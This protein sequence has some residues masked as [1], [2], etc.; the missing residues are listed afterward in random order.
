[1]AARTR[2]QRRIDTLE[3]LR[4]GGDAWVATA[5]AD[6]KP[7]LVALTYFW[8]G[9]RLTMATRVRSKTARN[10]TRGRWA[11]VALVLTGDVVILEGPVEVIPLDASD[12]LADAYAAATGYDV[13]QMPE[14][15]A[16]FR[17]MPT[18]IQ[19]MRSPEE[20]PD[21]TIMRDGR[22]LDD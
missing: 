15:W 22:W 1:M 18:R 13:R 20:E 9:E 21:R 14:P 6:G 10:L 8:D 3:T 12:G 16:F 19:A 17:L 11:R 4:R 2:A 5:S 7:H